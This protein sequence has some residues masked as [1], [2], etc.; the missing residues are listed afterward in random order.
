LKNSGLWPPWFQEFYKSEVQTG[1]NGGLDA[2]FTKRVEGM[3]QIRF[4]ELSSIEWPRYVNGIAN[5]FFKRSLIEQ[6]NKLR[7]SIYLS[8]DKCGVE[9]EYKLKAHDIADLIKK[10]VIKIICITAGCRDFLTPHGIP[11][12]LAEVI[13]QL[14]RPVVQYLP[15]EQDTVKADDGVS[16]F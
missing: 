2:E 16:V 3:A 6:L 15:V 7:K 9:Y 12:S 8:C 11:L 5:R 10:P 13:L 1:I 14:E 4:N